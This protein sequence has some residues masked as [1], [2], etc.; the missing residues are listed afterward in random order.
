MVRTARWIAVS[1]VALAVIGL[2]GVSSA[3]DKANASSAS[4]EKVSGCASKATAQN[5]DASG[6]CASKAMAEKAGAGCS[7][8]MAKAHDCGH[9]DLVAE[10]KANQGKVTLSTV[11]SENGVTLVFAAVT[12]DDVPA[13]KEVAS[14][15]FSLM[16]APAHC[17]YTRAQMAEKSCG[18]CKS[19]FKAF[20]DASVTL[21][22]NESGA[23]A[24]VVTKDEKQVE[25]L[26][27]FVA[28]LYVPEDKGE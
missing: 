8:K 27:A 20:A 7:S 22:E 19:A 11:T 1:V 13:A 24:I 23:E 3:C 12:K 21:E 28:S 9:C 18:D 14:H 17:A 16:N 4:A 6:G 15:A 26:Q 5:A 10:L 25:E 2:V